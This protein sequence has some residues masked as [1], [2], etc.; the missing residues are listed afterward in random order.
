MGR[1]L[2][3]PQPQNGESLKSFLLR[4]SMENHYDYISWIYELS[5]LKRN[6]TYLL[7][8]HK[9]DLIHLSDLV[10]IPCNELWK[11]TFVNEFN[12]YL[13]KDY[14]TQVIYR[15]GI[16]NK[17]SKVCPICISDDKYEQK[18]WDLKINLACNKH[19]ILLIN[20]C[21]KCHN[22]ILS[23]R[24]NIEYCMCG[25]PLGE[26]PRI[27]ANKTLVEMA[28]LLQQSQKK[29]NTSVT[30]NYNPLYN[31]SLIHMVSLLTFFSR[32]LTIY[33]ECEKFSNNNFSTSDKF[34]KLIID[35][36]E[37][38]MQWPNN[39]YSL[40]NDIRSSRMDQKGSRLQLSGVY[41][42]I[43]RKF[44]S[45][46][47]SFLRDEFYNFM[48]EDNTRNHKLVRSKTTL[49][50]GSNFLN[51]I[52]ITKLLKMKPNTV[53]V[54]V[55]NGILEGDYKDFSSYEQL[56]IPK[57]SIEKYNALIKENL[58]LK[59]V[60]TYLD[61]NKIKVI[62][63]QQQGL[64]HALLGPET[65]SREWLFSKVSVNSLLSNL[66]NVGIDEDDDLG[67]VID[68]RNASRI[69]SSYGIKIGDFINLILKNVILPN[70]IQQLHKGLNQL[71]FEKSKVEKSIKIWKRKNSCMLNASEISRIIDE[72]YDYVLLWL[73]AGLI[74]NNS[75][76]QRKSVSNKDLLNFQ[77]KY[78][79]LKKFSLKMN[80]HSTKLRRM[81]LEQNI[82][83]IIGSELEGGYLYLVNDVV[84]FNPRLVEES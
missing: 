79:S 59:E 64:I 16:I 57:E 54:L 48:R 44:S 25:F 66:L 58:G 77:K 6:S 75:D 2:L 7:S 34:Q 78:I 41:I 68:F 49:K 19:K 71:M 39:F 30:N 1:L 40:L 35:A 70:H 33:F 52:E 72:N 22:L 45:R 36:F 46:E 27:H 43:H 17:H 37:I 62:E 63:L 26:L 38:F 65:G 69:A 24:N 11:L 81:L 5:N 73:N 8:P 28:K 47:F 12:D 53:K 15:N 82:K 67:E 51:S 13:S 60:S 56:L 21:S 61:I 84:K 29:K 80:I 14:Y 20:K 18:I 10:G 31:L 83:P 9:S 50:E 3:V 42:G 74:K 55:R 32:Q 4:L 23:K 76:N